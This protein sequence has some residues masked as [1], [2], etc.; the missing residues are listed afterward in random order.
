LDRKPK[1]VVIAA[2]PTNDRKVVGAKGVMAQEVGFLL[3]KGQQRFA[4][5]R[6]EQ[7]AARHVS[8][9]ENLPLRETDPASGGP[10]KRSVLRSRKPFLIRSS[11]FFIFDTS[12]ENLMPKR[13]LQPLR[14]GYARVSTHE[15][16][17]EMQCRLKHIN[18][19]KPSTLNPN[20]ELYLNRDWK[21]PGGMP[22]RFGS[23]MILRATT[24]CICPVLR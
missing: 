20:V 21:E 11:R 23:A 18:I 16:N 14:I 12:I 5:G 13:E 4:L 9:L 15:Q 2:T 19:R 3:G 1:P 8:S 7:L 24:G 6:G 17:L 22:P 10:G